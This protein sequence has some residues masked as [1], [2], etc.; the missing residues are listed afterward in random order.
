MLMVALSWHV[1]FEVEAGL[2]RGV[3]AVGEPLLALLHPL[4]DQRQQPVL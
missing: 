4:L 2:G 3:Q 1:L